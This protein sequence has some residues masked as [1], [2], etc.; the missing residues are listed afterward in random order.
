VS[1]Q[2]FLLVVTCGAALLA[3]WILIRFTNFGPRSI[4]WTVV[5]V[6]LASLLLRLMPYALDATNA[7]LPAPDYVNVFGLAL[8]LLT[9]AF[10]SGGW[11]ARVARSMLRP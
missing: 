8:P 1:V 4:L 11:V 3:L 10:L 6:T 2:G 9:Y 5:H 7:R